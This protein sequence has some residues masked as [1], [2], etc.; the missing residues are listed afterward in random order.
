MAFEI[1][2]PLENDDYG[3]GLLLQEYQGSY[4]LISASR[5]KDGA[6]YKRWGFPSGKD[7]L[8]I[9]QVLPWQVKIGEDRAEAIEMLTYF[10]SQLG[11]SDTPGATMSPESDDIPF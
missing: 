11:S 10:L 1:F 2:R 6:V 9:D 8:P 5:G 4:F 3:K 7:K